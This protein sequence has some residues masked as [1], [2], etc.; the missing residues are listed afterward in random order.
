MLNTETK[1][2]PEPKW[3]INNENRITTHPNITK[4]TLAQEDKIN[5][6]LIK[7]I[8]TEMKTT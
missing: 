8:I 2:P 1:N 6:E 7:N 4:Q 3:K 5:V